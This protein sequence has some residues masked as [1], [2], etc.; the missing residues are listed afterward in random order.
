MKKKSL[1][2][3]LKDYRKKVGLSQREV[4]TGCG[5]SRA[6]IT[7]LEKGLIKDPPISLILSYLKTL[8][9]PYEKF[10]SDL[11]REVMREDR[12]LEKQ[13]KKRKKLVKDVRRYWTGISFFQK[14]VMS[15]PRYAERKIVSLLKGK[16]LGKQEINAY[17]NFALE[18][19]TTLYLLKEKWERLNPSL[20]RKVETLV[21]RAYARERKRLKSA[22][23]SPSQKRRKMTERYEKEREIFL[24]VEKEAKEYLCQK[25]IAFSFF[26]L[27]AV[28][29]YLKILRKKESLSEEEK[30][31]WLVE[32]VKIGLR[33][34]ILI[35]LA[36]MVEEKFLVL[37]DKSHQK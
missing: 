25:V 7:Q 19:F 23:P 2:E 20:L 15:F 35:D 16:N 8:G 11:E 30:E 3:L 33:R 14:G 5:K 9:I 34:E 18:Y 36:K 17:L 27:N 28:R 37:G 10:F 24:E 1:G 22:K 26:Y 12:N 13:E 29:R 6:L 4:A 21:R 31:N 32:G